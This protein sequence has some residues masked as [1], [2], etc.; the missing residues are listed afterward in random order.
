MGGGNDLAYEQHVIAGAMLG[1]MPAFEPGRASLDQRRVR[2]S[3]TESH[4]RKAIGVRAREATR[5]FDLIMGK[6][7]D[8]V[9][10]L[11]LEDRQT[12]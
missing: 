7:V 11:A 2:G 6:D 10:H 9:L 12:P 5:Q 1:V 4:T 8:G 3:K